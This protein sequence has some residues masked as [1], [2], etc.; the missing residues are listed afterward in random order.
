MLKIIDSQIPDFDIDM[1]YDKKNDKF[2][3]IS[4]NQKLNIPLNLNQIDE[5]WKVI[6]K[7]INNKNELWITWKQDFRRI[8]EVTLFWDKRDHEIHY[9]WLKFK[10]NTLDIEFAKKENNNTEELYKFTQIAKWI[11]KEN[12]VIE[13]WIWTPDEIWNK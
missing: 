2:Y 9:K 10:W 8:F 13:W 6:I 5:I 3:F 7:L 4:W 12:W 1:T 11:P